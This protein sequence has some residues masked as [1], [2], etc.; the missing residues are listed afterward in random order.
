MAEFDVRRW[1]GMLECEYYSD[2]FRFNRYRS[3]EDLTRLTKNDL[4]RLGVDEFD[5]DIILAAVER[6]RGQSRETATQDLLVSV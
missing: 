4:R 6:L 5:Q 1:L 3:I 2:Q